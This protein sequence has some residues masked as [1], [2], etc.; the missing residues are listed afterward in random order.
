MLLT[1]I[2][3]LTSRFKLLAILSV[4]VITF[5]TCKKEDDEQYA[6]IGPRDF[7]T[8]EKYTALQVEI[9]SVEGY[10]PTQETLDN[11]SAFMNE[12]LNK[13]GGIT[14]VQSTIETPA[15]GDYSYDDLI[16]VEKAQRDQN[17]TGNAVTLYVFFA[18]GHWAGNTSDEVVIGVAYSNSSIAIFEKTIQEYSG[19]ITQPSQADMETAILLHEF[20]HIMGLTNSGTPMQSPHEDPNHED[21]CNNENCLMFWLLGNTNMTSAIIGGNI[22]ELDDKCLADLKANGGK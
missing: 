5:S 16:S 14:Y 19:G 13:P 10:A 6:T 2:Q 15:K 22:P 9:V 18:D 4:I 17:T 11:F 8:S 7:L 21:H 1:T 3:S 12:R 20:G